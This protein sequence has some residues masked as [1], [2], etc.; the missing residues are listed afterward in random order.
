[1]NPEMLQNIGWDRKYKTVEDCYY[2][3]KYEEKRQILKPIKTYQNP[4]EYQLDQLVESLYQRLGLGRTKLLGL[5]IIRR[6]RDEDPA[7]SGYSEHDDD[8]S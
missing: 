1:T 8:V 5:K 7:W 3:E 2:K 6:C 4:T